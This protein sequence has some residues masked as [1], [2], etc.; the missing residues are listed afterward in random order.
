MNKKKAMDF[1]PM[2][3]RKFSFVFY[4]LKTTGEGHTPRRRAR[5][6]RHNRRFKMFS[7]LLVS[8]AILRIP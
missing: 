3:F 5:L 6:K 7:A 2:A 1:S 8:L 4:F